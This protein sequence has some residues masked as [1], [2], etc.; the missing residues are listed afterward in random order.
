MET[1]VVVPRGVGKTN[2]QQHI[3]FPMKISVLKLQ[4]CQ[5]DEKPAFYDCLSKRSK[6]TCDKSFTLLVLTCLDYHFVQLDLAGS[7]FLKAITV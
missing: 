7:G 6:H 2:M 5:F 1:A 4:A 3:D